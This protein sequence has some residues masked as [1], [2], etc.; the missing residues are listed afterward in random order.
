[1]I[2]VTGGFGFIGSNIVKALCPFDNNHSDVAVVD[3]LTNGH[4]FKNLGN[5][6]I[7]EY[8]DK[9]DLFSQ[10]DRFWRNITKI[11]HEG[12]ISSTTEWDGKK[13]MEENYTY[14]C[15]LLEKAIEYKIP[16][17]YASSASVYGT[18]THFKE[19]GELQPLNMYAYSKFL[20]D[21]KV[22]KLKPNNVQG[23][24]YFN[25]Y[26]NGE[27]HKGDQASPISKFIKQAKENGEIILFEGSDQYK[28]DFI[29]VDDI[30][31]YKLKTIN[32]P[33]SGIFNLGT[34]SIVSFEDIANWVS[35]KYNAKIK[36]I[37]FPDHLK[38]HYQEFTKANM[39]KFRSI[40]KFGVAN[41]ISV[42]KYINSL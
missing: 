1:M 3:D 7:N 29:C 4:K 24:R 5:T 9:D 36:Y 34:G 39:N 28:R 14:S 25:V 19:D 31:K 37:P 35:H 41:F 18:T 13:V 22:E 17:S 8:V 33:V 42:E 10:S 40:Q 21:K 11:F 20:F 2:L 27:E 26:G 30:V 6:V 38:G 15:K 32:E 16:M 12:A 23:F